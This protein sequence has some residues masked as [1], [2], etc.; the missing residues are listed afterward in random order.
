MAWYDTFAR[1]YDTFL[2]ATYA[3]HRA[4]ARECLALSPGMTVVDV[5]CGTGASFAHL[6]SAVGP[7]G[8]VIGADASAGMLRKAEA[9]VRRNGWQNVSLVEVTGDHAQLARQVSS[10][11][12][13]LFFLSLSVIPSWQTVL[14][15]WLAILAVGGKA[16]IADVY[17]PRPGAYARLVELIARASL[18][19]ASWRALAESTTSF[20]LAWQPS[21]WVLGG[22]FFLAGGTKRSVR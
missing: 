3:A 1:F 17:N 18:T 16:V 14:N 8:R 15:D 6:V 12:R 19:R 20:H 13:I 11:D 4:A 10:A 9:R 5:G 2:D 22:R 21:S 7:T